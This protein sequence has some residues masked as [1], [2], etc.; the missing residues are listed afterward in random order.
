MAFG[1]EAPPVFSG[2]VQSESFFVVDVDFCVEVYDE[3]RSLHDEE[4]GEHFRGSY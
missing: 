2:L 4:D 1:S 3:N